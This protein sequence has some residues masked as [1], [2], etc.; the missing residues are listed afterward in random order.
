MNKVSKLFAGFAALAML[1]ACSNDEPAAITKPGDG[2]TAYMKVSIKAAN[3]M[4]RYT[5]TPGY[6]DGN[7]NENKVN[8]VRFFFFDN[9]GAAM[10]LSAYLVKAE[11]DTITVNPDDPKND[12]VEAVFGD[13]LL[14]LEDL[15]SNQYPS[16]MI[17]VL[18]R[19]DFV[20]GT[21]LDNT[22][23]VLDNCKNGDYFVMSTASYIGENAHHDGKYHATKLQPTDFKQSA[24][25]AVADE[26][27]VEV[28]V[29][30]LAAKVQVG[31][32]ETITSGTINVGGETLYKLETTVA[33]GDNTGAGNV[34]NTQL[35]LRVLGWDLN[36]TAKNSY[37]CKNLNP[38][39]ALNWGS[40]GNWNNATDYRS[41][42]AK[43]HVYGNDYANIDNYVDYVQTDA[44]KNDLTA[45]TLKA[46]GA[47]VAYCNENT[48]E[49]SKI[50]S[51]EAV[52]EGVKARDLI[53][54]RV[55]TNVVLYTQVV[56]EE[57]QGVELVRANGVLFKADSYLQ[58]II[59]R[60]YAMNADKF[61]LWVKKSDNSIEVEGGTLSTQEYIQIGTDCFTL[62]MPEETDKE[63]VGDVDVVLNNDEF[64]EKTFYKK[65]TDENGTVIYT[66]LT[67]AEVAT[68]KAALVAAIKAA[69]PT[70]TNHA[71][72]YENGKNVYYI[73]VEH[74]GYVM[75]QTTLVEG[76]YGVVR[77]H[78]YKL[79]VSSFSKVG[80]GIW[81]PEE[82]NSESLKPDEPEN[83]LY[84]LGAH[85]NILSW[86]VV[87]QTVDL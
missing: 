85:I 6:E 1:A 33:G 8:S 32:A 44:W 64:A 63:G 71:V 52:P 25:A 29:E 24:A 65:G 13:N 66:P 54:N 74:L 68:A 87:D 69:Q 26:A 37:M 73:P 16:Y 83:P 30:R 27:P 15:T 56:D 18:N 28:Y 3:G 82:G 86:K 40:N 42:W 77:N 9:A 41:Y 84:Y 61:N 78:W 53:D 34:L 43:S 46:L 10:D 67:E 81:D 11:D 57:G 62:V 45:K 70:G 35:Y 48:N 23:E 55:A 31:L 72:I 21:N 47:D 80:H 36:T 79:T 7:T 51:K 75:D 19:P 59:N 5:T 39:W 38:A 22:L 76:S 2:D 4:S 12:N 17:T 20:P 14:V 50:A 58:Y 49:V 60:A